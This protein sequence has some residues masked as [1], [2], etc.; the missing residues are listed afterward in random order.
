[1]LPGRPGNLMT[2]EQLE[3]KARRLWR[4]EGARKAVL[5]YE[6]LCQELPESA[7]HFALLG[8]ALLDARRPEEAATAM[9]TSIW[10]RMRAGEKHRAAALARVLL[11][12][13][14]QDRTAQRAIDRLSQAA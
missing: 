6:R 4:R 11:R 14:A 7:R 2:I 5:V 8:A 12:L 10:L 13:V 9:R 1:M 3:H